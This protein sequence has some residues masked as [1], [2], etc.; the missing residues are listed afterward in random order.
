M[1]QL[2]GWLLFLCGI[3]MGAADLVPG[4]S[5]GTI[6]FIMGFYSQLLN[7]IK[8]INASSLKLLLKGDVR[9]FFQAIRWRFLL[10]LITGIIVAFV[11]FASLFHYLLG[12]ETYRIY[13]YSAFLGLI[14]ASFW[15]CIRQL[16]EWKAVHIVGMVFGAVI[17]YLFTGP[18]FETQ[19]Q[20]P[21]SVKIELNEN[22]PS[23]NNYDAKRGLLTHLSDY[24]LGAMF[25]KG[26]IAPDADVYDL[27]GGVIGK[28][29]DVATPYRGY[30]LDPWLVF[31]GIIAICGLLLPGISGSYLLT[32]LG[33]YP[34]VIG[35]LADFVEGLFAFSIDFDSFYTLFSLLIGILIGFAVFARAVSWLLKEYPKISI[36]VL[37]GFMIG[38]LRSVWPFWTYDYALLP[39]KLQK[40]PQ[41][42]LINP[43]CPSLTS[44][45]FF[46]A[47]IFTAIGFGSI[48]LVEYL[49]KLKMEADY[50]NTHD[51]KKGHVPEQ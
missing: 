13:L 44:P 29:V 10:T 27:S 30:K 4:I 2:K 23:L 28:V 50:Y 3:C 32:L 45:I 24:T 12:H 16:T 42:L 37:S 43:I 14:L 19:S 9:L 15:F 49:A 51:V 26:L 7:A 1:S 5:G 33:V 38:A 6:A 35:S 20:G 48:F 40:G 46:Y 21:F 31:C 34:L 47:L 8:S 39:L 36:A 22:F 41:L 18:F 25:S 17:A 11:S